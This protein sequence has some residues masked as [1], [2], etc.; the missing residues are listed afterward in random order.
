M[1]IVHIHHLLSTLGNIKQT[2]KTRHVTNVFLLTPQALSFLKIP[3][4]LLHLQLQ[5]FG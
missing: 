3:H 5:N 1:P 2:G 4:F